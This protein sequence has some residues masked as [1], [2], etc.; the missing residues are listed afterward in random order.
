VRELLIEAID[1]ALKPKIASLSTEIRENTEKLVTEVALPSKDTKRIDKSTMEVLF[2]FIDSAEARAIRDDKRPVALALT[3]R[4][5]RFYGRH[6][7]VEY[8]RQL[9]GFFGEAF[10]SI[11]VFD[12]DNTF[13]A[14][15]APEFVEAQIQ[16]LMQLFNTGPQDPSSA[17]KAQLERMHGTFCTATV[18]SDWKVSEALTSAVW[19]QAVSLQTEVPVLNERGI[20]MGLTSRSRLIEGVL[21]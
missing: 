19:H 4:R 10:G 15:L 11:L 17:I 20:F 2:D 3:V 21:S 12:R 18:Q 14:R 8:I 6:A 1:T 5:G 9:R 16:P 7:V 13:M